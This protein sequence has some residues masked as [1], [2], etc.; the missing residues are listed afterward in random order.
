MRVVLCVWVAFALGHVLKVNNSIQWHILIEYTFILVF[1]RY[2]IKKCRLLLVFNKKHTLKGCN[3]SWKMWFNSYQAHQLCVDIHVKQIPKILWMHHITQWNHSWLLEHY[4][5]RQ[6][7]KRFVAKGDNMWHEVLIRG[8]CSHNNSRPCF[9]S[10]SCFGGAYPIPFRCL[11][12]NESN[13]RFE[14][15]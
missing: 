11:M 10:F 7:L 12:D 6:C 4:W 5:K 3:E 2:G 1:Q 9:S 15:H 8:Y 13:G 14:N